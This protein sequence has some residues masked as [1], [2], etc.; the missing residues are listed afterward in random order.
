MRTFASFAAAVALLFV[1]EVCQA[2]DLIFLKDGTVM[3]GKVTGSDWKVVKVA[4]ETEA[5]TEDLTISVSRLEPFFYYRVRDK[6]LGD[7]APARIQL[8]LYAFDNELYSRSKI[9][10]QRAEAID[11]KVVEK[12]RKETLP[13][14]LEGFAAKVLRSAQRALRNGSTKMAKKYASA[15]LTK[16]PNTKAAVEAS[17]LLE[18][19]QK[20][21]D[22]K[23]DAQRAQRRKMAAQTEASEA[24]VAADKREAVL[25]PV[26]KAIDDGQ[27]HNHRGL[28]TKQT[29]DAKD[30]FVQAGG[31]FE[32]ALK[33][34]ATR[35]KDVTD[36]ETLAHLDS[37]AT[38][39]KQEGVDAYLNAA[40][41]LS[42][43]GSYKSALTMI[44]KAL[45]IDP[46]SSEAKTLRASVSTAGDGWN[47]RRGRR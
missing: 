35:R 32:H 4:A 17:A 42:A 43:R 33:M 16:A 41:L 38:Q 36:K 13:P 21:I 26:E 31:K 15:I 2:Q 12:F 39:A 1:A 20:K 24:K 23:E 28:T 46:D 22:E 29:T 40:N 18:E 44:H 5:G 7:D 30:A 3:R 37:L 9:Q 10:M 25:G 19:V 47:R 6:A 8:A 45:A 11:P 14:L 34:I 27:R